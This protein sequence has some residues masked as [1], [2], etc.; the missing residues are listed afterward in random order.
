MESSSRIYTSPSFNT[1]SSRNIANIAD[2]VVQELRLDNRFNDDDNAFLFV[3]DDDQP[4]IRDVCEVNT[5]TYAETL[6]QMDEDEQEFEFPV[7][8][9]D[10]NSRQ[11]SVDELVSG[12][13]MSPRYP[14]FDRKLLS[15]L[16]PNPG[17]NGVDTPSTDS[18]TSP[19]T[20]SSLMKLFIEDRDITSPSTSASSSERD[21]LD[22][23]KQ[24]TY[25]VW[26]P[27][28]DP[29]G[30]HKK[31]NSISIENTLNRWKVR[32]LLKRSY[33]D[34]SY[35]GKDSPVFLF[36]PPL[37]PEK[38]NKIGKTVKTTSGVGGV[39]GSTKSEN[40][41]PAYKSKVG[42]IRLP[43]YLPYRQDQVAAYGS[44]KHLYRY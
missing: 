35:S 6:S 28:T 26:K 3:H 2:R 8:Y 37:S 22:G 39:V 12:N 29:R 44:N 14:L 5:K 10:A 16:N 7:I 36:I 1:H 13:Q 38:D 18:K 21:D 30:K 20:R 31:S 15:E 40:K 42:N 25:C 4:E 11:D 23:I 9:G 19:A 24:G 33:S 27:N 43:P 34:D 17:E 41:N 32:D